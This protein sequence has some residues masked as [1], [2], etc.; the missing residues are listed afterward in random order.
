MFYI[1]KW[2]S[3]QYVSFA[4]DGC[5]TEFSQMFQLPKELPW[6]LLFPPPAHLRKTFSL[7]CFAVPPPPMEHIFSLGSDSHNQSEKKEESDWF[8][9]G[10]EGRA[11]EGLIKRPQATCTGVR[12][13]CWLMGGVGEHWRRTSLRSDGL[14]L[15]CVCV[16]WWRLCRTSGTKR[17]LRCGIK[18]NWI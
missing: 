4:D 2:L 18:A 3:T 12:V 8:G 1:T 15:V 5:I 11:S 7:V 17:N 13:L 9:T 6:N 14:S 10:T 16:S